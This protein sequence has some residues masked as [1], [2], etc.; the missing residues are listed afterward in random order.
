MH[1]NQQT[2]T[3]NF[4]YCGCRVISLKDEHGNTIY[5]E[6]TIGAESEKPLFIQPG[7]ETKEIVEK[8]YSDLEAQALDLNQNPI[9]CTILG[10]EVEIHSN[11]EL[12]QFDNSTISLMSGTN[13][14]YCNKC[15]HTA[16][17][18]NQR[19][20]IEAGFQITRTIEQTKQA[21]V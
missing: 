10:K 9:H 19:Q 14:S 16:H 15:D 21:R 4:I 3:H 13:G 20:N 5:Q 17:T 6:M 7:K 12:T 1:S 8:L 2:E 18:A 11:I